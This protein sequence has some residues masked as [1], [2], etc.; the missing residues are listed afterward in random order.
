MT[1]TRN[2]HET[3]SNASDGDVTLTLVQTIGDAGGIDSLAVWLT[4]SPAIAMAVIAFF[5]LC[6]ARGQLKLG[7]QLKEMQNAFNLQTTTFTNRSLTIETARLKHEVFERQYPVYNA[8]AVLMSRI[9]LVDRLDDDLLENYRVARSDAIFAFGEDMQDYLDN[10]YLKAH[11]LLDV[12]KKLAVAEA[13]GSDNTTLLKEESTL[14]K[15]FEDEFP[16]KL[17]GRFLPYMEM[18]S[19]PKD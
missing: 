13:S 4:A 19:L 14:K 15:H 10:Q 5:M 9:V 17:R 11:E 12:K 8:A 6:V 3:I 7:G 1:D 2:I 16:E 18:P